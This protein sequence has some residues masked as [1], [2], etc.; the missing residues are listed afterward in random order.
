MQ[1]TEGFYAKLK[2]T[3][4]LVCLL[5]LRTILFFFF[6]GSLFP[7]GISDGTSPPYLLPHHFSCVLLT[8]MYFR[9]QAE[10]WGILSKG[11]SG[12]V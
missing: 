5:L 12:N 3:S 7:K 4:D 2:N 11:M 8:K 6:F 10:F 1:I 9:D